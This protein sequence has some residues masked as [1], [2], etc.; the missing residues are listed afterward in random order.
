MFNK[1]SQEE[2]DR[3]LELAASFGLLMRLEPNKY[4]HV[5]ISIISSSIPRTEFEKAQRVQILFNKLVDDIARDTDWLYEKLKNVVEVDDFSA[6]M[7][8]I[9]KKLHQEGLR[10][11]TFLGLHRS[12]YMLHEPTQSF[13]QVELNTIAS[14]FGGIATKL[15]DLHELV[16]TQYGHKFQDA[17]DPKNLP[18]NNAL[19]NLAEGIYHA[20]NHYGRSG[21]VMFL[22]GNDE[23][24]VFDQSYLETE[25][26]TQ[27]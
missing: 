17:P 12:D 2:L 27:W 26:W 5:P 18:P 23:R 16:L 22:V 24:N 19:H 6:H 9:S 21:T 15:R 1:F 20:H 25:L 14:S 10:Q 8:E 4:T 7:V 11:T 13:L 3:I